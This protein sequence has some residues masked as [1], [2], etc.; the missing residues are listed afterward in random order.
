MLLLLAILLALA[1]GLVLSVSWF[2]DVSLPIGIAAVIA[3]AI[4]VLAVGAAAFVSARRA[5]RSFGTALSES[6]KE[7]FELLRSLL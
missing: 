6:F 3:I 2:V 4:G 5:R 7:A 1:G